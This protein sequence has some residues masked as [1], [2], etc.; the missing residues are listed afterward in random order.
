MK[1]RTS[2]NG[3]N[4]RHNDS[5]RGTNRGNGRKGEFVRLPRES[6]YNSIPIRHTRWT[7]RGGEIS[8]SWI[9]RKLSDA[10]NKIN[11]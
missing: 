4:N 8:V 9:L 11:Y 6:R 2:R 10:M 7:E 1:M 3:R 5:Q